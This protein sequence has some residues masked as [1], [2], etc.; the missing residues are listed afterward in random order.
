MEMQALTKKARIKFL[1]LAVLLWAGWCGTGFAAPAQNVTG[2]WLDQSGRAGIF[3]APCGAA[4]CGAIKWL[5]N[6]LDAAGQPRA[7][8]HNQDTALRT[9]PLCGLPMLDSFAPDGNGGWQGGHIY[10]PENGKTYKSVM[11]L[12]ADGTLHVRGYIGI[13]LLGRSEIW[14]RPAASLAPCQ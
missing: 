13:P 4:L 1:P 2:W 10:D 11:H 12:A 8:I 9:R 6:P 14:T 5:R 7:D 3:I